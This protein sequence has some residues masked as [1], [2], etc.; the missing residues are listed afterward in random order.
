MA[1][2]LDAELLE[3]VRVR[4][5]R[6][7]DAFLH[8]TLRTRRVTADNIRRLIISAILAAIAC[9]ACAGVSFVKAHIHQGS[10][11]AVGVT[12]T[13]PTPIERL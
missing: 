8:G 6:L 5:R 3:S 13:V 12:R 10:A 9:A 7:R 1:R 2:D 4:R 11:P